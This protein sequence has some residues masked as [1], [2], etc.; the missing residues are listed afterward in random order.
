MRHEDEL[1]RDP[2]RPE[3][4]LLSAAADKIV[5]EQRRFADERLA[6]RLGQAERVG[7]AIRKTGTA[8]DHRQLLRGRVDRAPL[9]R[10]C[11]RIGRPALEPARLLVRR[12]VV[13]REHAVVRNDV[14]RDAP[15]GQVEGVGV[16]EDEA[17]FDRH[18][19]DV[20]RLAVTRR[21]AD[22]GAMPGVPAI[23]KA[24]ARE[25][26]TVRQGYSRRF[27]DKV[28][29]APDKIIICGS[30][31]PLTAI[32]IIRHQRC[33][34]LL[35]NGAARSPKRTSL[36]TKFPAKREYTGISCFLRSIYQS[37][38][39]KSARFCCR[40]GYFPFARNREFICHELRNGRG[41]SATF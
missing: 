11:G 24:V 28:A 5:L 12:G 30:I 36:A 20:V 17:G 21:Q 6:H 22:P 40:R 35:G 8:V 16:M 14:E 9:H 31:K 13:G 39:A 15:V 18:T 38:L 19:D 33:L 41:L 34:P 7:V 37:G 10:P 3:M 29:V 27:I 4:V 32:P 1:A 2:P 25:H 23:W 26:P